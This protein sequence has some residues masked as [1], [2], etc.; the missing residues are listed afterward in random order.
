MSM[1][2]DTKPTSHTIFA[3]LNTSIDGDRDYRDHVLSGCGCGLSGCGCPD[4]G[5]EGISVGGYAVAAI[6]A[7]LVFD[8]FRAKDY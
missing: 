4:S 1:E 8:F 2:I 3:P 6:L 5:M 7:L